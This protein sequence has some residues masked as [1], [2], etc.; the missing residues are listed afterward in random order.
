SDSLFAGATHHTQHPSSLPKIGEIEHQ[1]GRR[2]EKLRPV[3]CPPL[4]QDGCTPRGEEPSGIMFTARAHDCSLPQSFTDPSRPPTY[5]KFK[6]YFSNDHGS[7]PRGIP[8]LH[9]RGTCPKRLAQL[10]L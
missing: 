6:R 4:P 7:F 2:S 9:S 10:S 3:R 1:L 5:R 8:P